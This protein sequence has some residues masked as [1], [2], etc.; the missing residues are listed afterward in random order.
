MAFIITTS[1]NLLAPQWSLVVGLADYMVKPGNQ[2]GVLVC[3]VE[4]WSTPCFMGLY[5]LNGNGVNG[6][7]VLVGNGNGWTRVG[8]NGNHVRL[9]SVVASLPI[10][11][12]LPLLTLYFALIAYILLRE[13]ERGYVHP[14]RDSRVLGVATLIAISIN[15]I[16]VGALYVDQATPRY[17]LPGISV[18]WGFNL[19]NSTVSAKLL[20]SG[21]YILHS[22]TCSYSPIGG[23]TSYPLETIIVSGD[24]V[25]ATIPSNIYEQVYKSRVLD[26]TPPIPANLSVYEAIPVKCRFTLDKGVFEASYL[27]VFYWRDLVVRV[28]DSSVVVD[29]PNPVGV[30]AS[31]YVVDLERGRL[32]NSTSVFLEPLSSVRIDLGLYGAGVYRVIVQYNLLGLVRTRVVETAVS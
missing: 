24:T 6:G 32:L 2:S 30:N 26:P 1:D 9:Y 31:I 15:S 21:F 14:L 11:I 5:I 7:S 28:V 29:N 19:E 23:N 3:R 27:A 13:V 20:L 22:A 12:W 16:L 8:L 25:V 18:E 10:Y 17:S 4:A